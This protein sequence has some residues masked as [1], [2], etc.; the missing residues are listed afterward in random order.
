L[1]AHC[2]SRHF[3]VIV[4]SNEPMA[5]AATATAAPPVAPASGVPVASASAASTTAP[6]AAAGKKAPR[7]RF[8]LDAALLMNRETGL[9]WVAAELPRSVRRLRGK[10]HEAADAALL[11]DLYR[12]WGERLYPRAS[13]PDLVERLERLGSK[14]IVHSYLRSGGAVLTPETVPADDAPAAPSSELLA[15]WAVPT[16]NARP[17]SPSPS[18]APPSAAAPSMPSLAPSPAAFLAADDDWADWS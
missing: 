13:F 1:Y 8:V 7:K 16:L 6:G 17:A 5:S 3:F 10:G 2:V 15:T 12:A 14:R 4:S 9:P 11:V 18:P